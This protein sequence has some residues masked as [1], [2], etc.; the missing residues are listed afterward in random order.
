MQH[1]YVIAELD[2]LARRHRAGGAG[3]E[4]NAG[5]TQAQHRRERHALKSDRSDR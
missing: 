2:F 3:G 1:T 5:G 4:E